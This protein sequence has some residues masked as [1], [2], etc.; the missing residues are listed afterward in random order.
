MSTENIAKQY[1]NSQVNLNEIRT[2]E[3]SDSLSSVKKV[4]SQELEAEK[5]Y[6]NFKTKITKFKEAKSF[7]EAKEIAKTVFNVKD[8]VTFFKAGNAKC[9]IVNR[10]KALR[11]ILDSEK[12]QICYNFFEKMSPTNNEIEE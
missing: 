5:E 12:E 8:E 2:A 4:N 3:A 1:L 6:E 9:V 10:G 7:D 11:I